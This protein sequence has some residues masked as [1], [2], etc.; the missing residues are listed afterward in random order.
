MVAYFKGGNYPLY[1]C[2]CTPGSAWYVSGDVNGDCLYNGLDI[3]YGVSYL[4]GGSAPMACQDCPPVGVVTAGEG[5]DSS[6]INLQK[7]KRGNQSSDPFKDTI[8]K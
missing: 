3:G 2:E 4:K 7:S 6:N 5:N 1:E 8:S